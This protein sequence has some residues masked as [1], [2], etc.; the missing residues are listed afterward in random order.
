MVVSEDC[1]MGKIGFDVLVYCNLLRQYIFVIVEN[2]VSLIKIS[3]KMKNAALKDRTAF[4]VYMVTCR[5]KKF[6]AV[7]LSLL[8]TSVAMALSVSVTSVTQP[9]T[10]P[11][12]I[13]G[14][15]TTT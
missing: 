7:W 2:F 11:S 1:M 3:A 10:S 13:M 4:W 9:V 14:A 8:S 12:E 5:D 6:A 15:A